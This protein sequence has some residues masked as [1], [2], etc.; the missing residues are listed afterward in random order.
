MTSSAHALLAVIEPLPQWLYFL[1]M[2]VTILLA[3]FASLFGFV[4]LRKK[5]RHHHHHHRRRRK[6]AELRKLN[7]TLAE[8]GGLPPA[9]E[10]KDSSGQTPGQ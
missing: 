6:R 10:E 7:P 8:T 9:R 4:L 5:I 3:A 1:I 2:A